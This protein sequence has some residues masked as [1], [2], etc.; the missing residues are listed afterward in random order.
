MTN[1]NNKLLFILNLVL[2]MPH[3]NMIIDVKLHPINS[4]D[5]SNQARQAIT[6]S[7]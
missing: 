6:S 4:L 5:I 2:S 3:G 1:F 7:K